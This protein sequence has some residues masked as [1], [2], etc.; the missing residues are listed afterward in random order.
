MGLVQV[1][2]LCHNRRPSP[3]T[4]A[5]WNWSELFAESV[6]LVVQC[7]VEKG[8]P[9]PVGWMGARRRRVGLGGGWFL[10]GLLQ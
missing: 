3:I 10:R 9:G 7:S 5:D 8:L 1:H 4:A 6:V 2:D